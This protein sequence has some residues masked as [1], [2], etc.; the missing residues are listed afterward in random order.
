M[1]LTFKAQINNYYRFSNLLGSAC[2]APAEV[3]KKLLERATEPQQASV[4]K[5]T[6]PPPRSVSGSCQIVRSK[7]GFTDIFVASGFVEG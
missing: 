2:R 4:Q 6:Y 1:I 7:N 3:N 5:S